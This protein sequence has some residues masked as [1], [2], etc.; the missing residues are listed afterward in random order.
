MASR[1]ANGKPSVSSTSA[2]APVAKHAATTGLGPKRS[3]AREAASAPNSEPPFSTARND[4]E[5][6]A[7]KPAG[8]MISGSQVL[9]EYTSIRPVALISP[10]TIVGTT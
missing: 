10:R 1:A 8:S 7:L 3:A 9:S 2:S 4:S 6:F 5:P